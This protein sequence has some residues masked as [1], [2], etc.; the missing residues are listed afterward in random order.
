MTRKYVE[1]QQFTTEASINSSH[2][3]S[4]A[5]SIS[6]STIGSKFYICQSE[7]P[8]VSRLDDVANILSPG[9]G[10]YVND[11]TSLPQNLE[12]V[13]TYSEPHETIIA[14]EKKP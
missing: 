2:L 10:N 9:A 12:S 1:K 14:P 8:H 11:M 7:I 13:T 6:Q 4:P 5:Y 3:D